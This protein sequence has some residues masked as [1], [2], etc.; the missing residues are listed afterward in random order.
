MFKLPRAK[1][2]LALTLLGLGMVLAFVA[3][4]LINRYGDFVPYVHQPTA[5]REVMAFLRVSKYPPSLEFTL[6][7]LGPMLVLLPWLERWKAQGWKCCA[8]SAACRCSST[9]CTSI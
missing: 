9:C 4:R 2:D 7:T 8:P 6:A 3:L 1:R 5:G